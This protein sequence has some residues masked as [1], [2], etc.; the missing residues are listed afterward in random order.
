VTSCIATPGGYESP[1]DGAERRIHG[2]H[3]SEAEDLAT[4]A[5][6][7]AADR[8]ALTGWR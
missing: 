8:L 5:A 6:Q 1:A 3:V 2:G 7:P 4:V